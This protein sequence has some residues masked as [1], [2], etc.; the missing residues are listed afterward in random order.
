ML[1]SFQD[2]LLCNNLLKSQE[3]KETQTSKQYSEGKQ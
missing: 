3:T 2:L 1:D